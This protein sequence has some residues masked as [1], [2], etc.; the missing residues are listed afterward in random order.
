MKRKLLSIIGC[1]VLIMVLAVFALL[2]NLSTIG[3]YVVKK[4]TGGEVAVNKFD[5]SFDGGRLV[6]KLSDLSMKGNL[7][8]T[9]KRL[10][11]LANFA[12]R[13]FLKSTTIADFDLTFADLKGKTRFLPL[14]AERL[15]IK[16][17][18]ITYNK[19]KIFIEELTIENL[20]SGKPFLFNLKARN[21]SFFKDVCAS[22]EGLY[23]GKASELKG[24]MYVADLD[25]SRLSS[26]LKGVAVVQGP[27]TFAR[28][29]FGFE[30]S[31]EMSGFEVNDRVLEKPL[32]IS[33]Y[34]G[35][36]K[37]TYSNDRVDITIENINFLNTI[38]FLNLKTD[39]KNLITL[40]LSSGFVN[41]REVKNFI[42]FENLAKGSRKMW[43]AIQEGKVKITRFHFEKKK[44]VHADLE[45]EDMR[46]VYRDMSFSK[47]E[48]LLSIDN[49]KMTISKG[50]GTFKT[51]HFSDATGFVSL[52]QDKKAKVRGNYSVDLR[53]I[54]YILD[55]G[56]VKFKRGTTRGVIELEG[57]K[58]SGYGI[59]GTG[60]VDDANVSWQKISAHARGSYRFTDEE[61][62]FDPLIIRKAGTDMVI[63]GKWG[64]KSMGIFLKGNLDV[65]LVK[66]YVALPFPINGVTFL[67][68]AIQNR[69][70]TFLLNGDMVMDDIS[71]TIPKF[72]KKDKG[73]RSAGHIKASIK[74]KRIDIEHLSYNLDI[75]RI[76]GKGSIIPNGTINFTIGMNAQAVER[77]TPLFFFESQAPKGDLDLNIAFKDLTWPVQ[78]IPDMKGFVRVNNG[79][80][81][82]PWFAEP[83]K[84]I[85]LNAEFKG[86]SSEILVKRI[87]CGQTTVGNSKLHLE[88]QENPRFS[89]SVS[90]DTFNLNDFRRD[91]EFALRSISKDNL[92][93]KITGDFS[94]QAGTINLPNMSGSQLMASG[95]FCERKLNIHR[96]TANVLGGYA[97]CTGVLDLSQSIPVIGAQGKIL[98]ITSG[99]LLHVLG[100]KTSSVEGEGVVT[101]NLFFRGE[102]KAD[103][104]ETLQGE[105]NMYSRDGTI[106]KWDLLAKVFSLLNLYDLFR[107]KV[108]FTEA[109]L[110]YAKM[111]ASFKVKEGLFATDNFLLD[112]PSMLITGK[113]S[114]NAKNQEVDGTITVS[115][116]VAFDK[117]IDKIPIL[118]RIVRN[119]DRGF[120]YA[121]Y[122]VK[123]NAEDPSI[124]LNY[125]NTIGGRTVDTLKNLITLPLEL[126]ERKQLKNG[127]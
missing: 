101:G 53:D 117:T 17:G 11:V 21:G 14:P 94:I 26:K 50:R 79:F 38:F 71:F 99:H 7:Q 106:R 52:A 4:I 65:D 78:K 125:V 64:K 118:R 1:L 28:Q 126:F 3:P 10:D 82:L 110:K 115:P 107:G 35:K 42:A 13:P 89:L 98:S 96:L 62:I 76:N 124:S 95:N 8:G 122:N 70:Q 121:S 39:K 22:G 103:F 120:I 9:I 54:P 18:A 81:R 116:L 60:K 83:L 80:L 47:V 111:G 100:T 15:E 87:V 58:T 74:E 88:G 32:A 112:S 84:E 108:R 73:I 61:I 102:K 45:L 91:S 36:T 127:Q 68:M 105:V 63:R 40:D 20:K 114:I 33:R 46:F 69:N 31:F 19:Q 34:A 2:L 85:N 59:S 29:S 86:G 6:F 75:L 41:V 23:K 123:G 66:E 24:T 67:D 92:L 56:K 16:R 55:V 5:Y 49:Y 44:P 119:K 30:G 37:A 27:F 43:D 104:I 90:M 77:I 109:G 57:D 51:S 12:S 48:G 93:A 25:L 113:G 97:D 72:M